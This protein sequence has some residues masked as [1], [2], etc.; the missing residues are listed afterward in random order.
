MEGMGLCLCVK[1]PKP[2][3]GDISHTDV[4]DRDYC[5]PRLTKTDDEDGGRRKRRQKSWRVRDE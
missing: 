4:F 5:T 1:V 2:L 3:S